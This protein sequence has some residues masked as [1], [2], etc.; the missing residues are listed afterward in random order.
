MNNI[1]DNNNTDNN[2]TDNNYTD[3]NN[4]D[5]NY[6]DNLDL[7]PPKSHLLSTKLE[8]YKSRDFHQ[9]AYK[10]YNEIP[11]DEK[12]LHINKF[13]SLIE[14][15]HYQAPELWCSKYGIWDKMGS[16]LNMHFLDP[17]YN[18]ISKIFNH[19]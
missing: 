10:I 2:Y 17:K 7:C 11:Y 16:Y 4:T 1:T 14:T 6:T 8:E 18:S 5:N 3:N 9:I 19:L 13:N 15:W 12:H